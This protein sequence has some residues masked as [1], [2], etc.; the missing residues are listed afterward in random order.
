MVAVYIDQNDKVNML[1]DKLKEMNL[2]LLNLKHQGE[3]VSKVLIYLKREASKQE[4]SL[5]FDFQRTLG[6]IG[7]IDGT[8]LVATECLTQAGH[9][10]AS[11]DQLD[12]ITHK[13]ES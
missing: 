7:V 11:K 5:I 1:V 9:K 2:H 6:E 4:V 12:L 13:A 10:L 8:T 3:D